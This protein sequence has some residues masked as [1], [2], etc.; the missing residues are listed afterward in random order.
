MDP[1][2]SNLYVFIG[3]DRSA[4]LDTGRYKPNSY[5]LKMIIR[6]SFYE[7]ACMYSNVSVW[8]A[9]GGLNYKL[10]KP[11]Q[12]F[13]KLPNQT[14]PQGGELPLLQGNIFS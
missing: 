1:F 6:E 11:S 12:K 14:F 10:F 13:Q 3:L 7:M 5:S 9:W 8:I 2:V 4:T